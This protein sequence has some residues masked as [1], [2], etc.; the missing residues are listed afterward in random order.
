M[1]K[2]TINGGNRLSGSVSISG[3]KNASLPIMASS[4][5]S[6]GVLELKNIPHV[7]DIAIMTNILAD[8]G[9]KVDL[10]ENILDE[11][12]SLSM[13][14]NGQ[15][16]TKFTGEYDMVRQMRA[17]FLILGPLLARFGS[18][19]VSLPG[20]CAIGVRPIDIH[21]EAFVK[22]GAKVDIT[23]GY[24]E[25]SVKRKL[26]GEQIDFKFPSVGATQNVMMAATLAQGK[27]IINGAAREV[28]I[29]DLANCLR[30]MGAKITGDGGNKIEIT[31]VEFLGSASH[32]VISD[33]IEAGTYILATAITDGNLRIKNIN[34]T[35]L[36]G[37]YDKMIEA[38]ISIKE[39]SENEIEV[40]RAGDKIKTINIATGPAPEFPTDMQAQFMALTLFADGKSLIQENIF[41]NRFMH[42]MELLRMGADI[43]CNKNIATISGG[44][45][46]KPAKVMA[47]DLRASVSLVLTALAIKGKT[48]INRIYHLERGYER[49]A[50]KLNKCGADVNISYE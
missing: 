14:L 35:L 22:M 2:I 27:T 36:R 50:E 23:D 37:F 48:T 34:K 29:I 44:K 39:L 1:R 19:R 32:Q 26:Q 46:L 7:S 28:E 30:A 3:S 18:A 25:V 38:G 47:T 20:G 21:L 33:K 11:D 6:S 31:G 10:K 40:K 13:C 4:I 43:T 5:L 42:V 41:E 9:I 16:I 45:I 15:N 49:L 12:F 24:V 17:S 8:L